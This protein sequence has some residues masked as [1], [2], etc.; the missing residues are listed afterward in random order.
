[1]MRTRFSAPLAAIALAAFVGAC[2][3]DSSVGPSQ[4]PT[5][6][7]VLSEI[8]M[9]R[10]ASATSAAAATVTP[11]RMPALA[12]IVPSGCSYDGT[13]KFTCSPITASGVTVTRAFTLLDA[14]NK[15]Q[16]QYD[17]AT[18]AAVT[19]YTTAAG[20]FTAGS[21]SVTITSQETLTLSG[22]LTGVHT[23]D[24][25][26][27]A[28]ISSPASGTLPAFDTDVTTTIEHLVLPTDANK[29][30]TG[31][32]TVN[33]AP[34]PGSGPAEPTFGV[35]MVFDGTGTA[36]MTVTI[37]SLP[38]QTCTIDLASQAPPRC[39]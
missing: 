38:A 21:R 13:S 24:G 39:L 4:P 26:S 5:L 15:P 27:V 7:Q 10:V 32:I 31:T 9:S 1:M 16:S 33:V 11:V 30:P 28:H 35:K 20:T 25:T 34:A 17:P 6:D 3:S 18:T 23:L 22:L 12:T 8:S 29:Y 14:S 19:T 2:R 36:K 37:G